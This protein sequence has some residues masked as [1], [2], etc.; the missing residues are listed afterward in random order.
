M[1]RSGPIFCCIYIGG[2]SQVLDIKETNNNF[3]LMMVTVLKM[4]KI[5]SRYVGKVVI[6]L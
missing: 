6:V 5:P 4:A 1:N 3:L 2:A